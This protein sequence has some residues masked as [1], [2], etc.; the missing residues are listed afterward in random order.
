MKKLAICIPSYNRAKKCE[1]LLRAL[2]GQIVLGGLYEKVE[3]CV[4][5]DCS[6]EDIS[7]IA[8]RVRAQ[9]AEIDLRF[10][11]NEKNMG[12]DYNFLKCVYMSDAEYCW[13]IGNDDMPEENGVR[14]ILNCLEDRVD[15]LVFPF[16]IYDEND[17]KSG[18]VYPLKDG[19]N[20]GMVFHTS[21][22]EE[23]SA[24]IEKVN[25]GNALFCFLSNVVFKKE[26]WDRHG[27]RFADKMNTIFIQMYMNLQTLK[28]GA[29][30]KYVPYKFI[31]NYADDET[32]AAF[33][34]EYDVLIG[35]SDVI[36]YFFTGEDHRKLQKCI[37]DER[38]NGRM[39]D[40]D[41]NSV[42]K[43]RIA[44]IGS[45]KVELYKRYFI[46]TKQRRSYFENRNV[47]VYGAGIFGKKALRDLKECNTE[48]I[49]VF[50]ADANKWGSEIEGYIVNPAEKLF[51]VNCN[52][53]CV[54]VVANNRC[55]I[56]IVEMLRFNQVEEIAVIT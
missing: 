28:E 13:I 5:D 8:G 18:T 27:D 55:L 6:V 44:Q 21:N 29:L 10:R 48:S 36:D 45:P 32:N 9:Y 25:N 1:R 41:E 23:Y 54:V 33:K 30:Y 47:L 19:E 12:M 56:E 34:R 35:L 11:K 20:N 40:L 52:K 46:S 53:N 49:M 39:W 16:D 42:E 17:R 22:G 26:A 15:F 43:R 31:R 7:A 38:I 37:V 50:D 4:S 51:A 2:A 14:N 3:I 24:L